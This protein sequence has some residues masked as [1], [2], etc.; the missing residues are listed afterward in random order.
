MKAAVMRELNKPLTIEE[1]QIDKPGPNELLVRTAASGICHSDLHVL[2]GGIPMP[3]PCVLGHEPAGVVEEVGSDVQGF[4]KGDHVIGC[5]NAWCGECEWC[6][7][8][9]PYLCLSPS[10]M[11]RPEGLG[12]RLATPDG[13]PMGQF[14]LSSFAELMLTHERGWVKIRKDMP[15]DRAALIGCGVTTGIGAALRTAQVEPGATAAIIGCGGVGLSA[16][17][18]A[19]IAG[20][21]RVIAV[22]NQPWKLDLTRKLGATDTVNSNDGDPIAQVMELT[23]GL[24]VDYAFECIGLVPTIQQAVMMAKKGGA[25]VLVGVLPVTQTVELSASLI[26]LQEKR[27]LGSFMGSNRFRLDMPNYV[28]YYLDGRLNLDEMISQAHPLDDVNPALGR[29]AQGRGGAL[30]DHLRSLGSG[31]DLAGLDATAQAA[32]VRSGEV[33]ARELVAAAIHRIE[34]LDG[35]LNA[36]IHRR[37]ERALEESAAVDET[38]PFAGVPLLLKDA[39]AQQAGEPHHQGLAPLR[40]AQFRESEDSWFVERLCATGFV[41]L[42][43]T[44]APELCTLP[45]TEPRAFGAT[46]NPWS[47]EHSTGG[48]SGG[49]GAAVAAGLVPLAHASDGGGLHPHAGQLLRPGGAQAESRP[50]QSRAPGGRVLGRPLHGRLRHALGAGQRCG[51]R[52]GE[53]SRPGGSRL[54]AAPSCV[55]GGG[56]QR[57]RC[58]GSPEGR[59]AYRGLRGRRSHPPGLCGGGGRRVRCAGGA[60]SRAPR[61]RA[62]GAGRRRDSR[63]AGSGGG[64][65]PGRGT[66]WLESQPGTRD[67]AQ[68]ARA[69]QRHDD[70]GRA[71]HSRGRLR[72][73]AR[74]PHRLFAPGGGVVGRPG[75]APHPHA[76]RPPRRVWARY[77]GI[78]PRKTG[79]RWRA[80]SAG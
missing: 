40:D 22:D 10:V 58:T 55:A 51:A 23:G 53:R 17:Q 15:L 8:G 45:T 75:S 54:C 73:S 29:H 18:G 14:A 16:L 3:A 78:S 65:I 79:R 67:R 68:R 13:A 9:Q 69:R 31:V 57:A 70:R 61:R 80:A 76:H 19:R 4:E 34:K 39:G 60:G 49:S 20:A 12:P 48:S 59:R 32:L 52:P 44:N 2:E 37:F 47:L 28:D 27:V 42:G 26:T 66:G 74:G 77:G 25:A 33:E 56:C 71:Q 63:P 43:R 30:G 11:S 46:R 50:H 36:V 6:L 38:R 5:L 35:T 24:G 72:G 64:R 1:I 62:A 21:S 7:K 41:I